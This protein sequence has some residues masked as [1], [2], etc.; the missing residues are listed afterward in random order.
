M[1]KIPLLIICIALVSC[2]AKDSTNNSGLQAATEAKQSVVSEKEAV[3]T[4]ES[5]STQQVVSTSST[6]AKRD[7]TKI[8]LDLTK[9]S[10]TM[11][12]STIFDMLIM[13]EDYI[14]KNIKVKGWFET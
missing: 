9:M 3:E 8:D 7:P 13:P 4:L 1:K 11:I 6:T 12:Y 10:A 2:K 5:T 14:E